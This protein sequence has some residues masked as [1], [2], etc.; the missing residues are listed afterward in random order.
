M[1]QAY[2]SQRLGRRNFE[3]RRNQ[4]PVTNTCHAILCAICPRF[5]ERQEMRL[6]VFFP[7]VL[8]L[9]GCS[10]PS[11]SPEGSSGQT[12]GAFAAAS[13]VSRPSGGTG[14]REHRIVPLRPMTGDVEILSGDPERV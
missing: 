1:S 14:N 5:S 4:H 9:F 3:R 2:S 11:P 12:R 8:V 6:R 13:G 7:V 10:K